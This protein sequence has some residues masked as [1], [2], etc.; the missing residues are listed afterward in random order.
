MVQ[1]GQ[2]AGSAGSR[3]E[4][5]SRRVVLVN[6]KE[7]LKYDRLSLIITPLVEHSIVVV[8]AICQV[9]YQ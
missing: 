9:K 7:F 2:L 5:F 3:I 6:R 4:D 1:A 8:V